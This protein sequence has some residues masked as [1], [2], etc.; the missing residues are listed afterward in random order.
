MI[1]RAY[2]EIGNV[3]NMNCSFCVG[4][5]RPPRQMSA[6]EFE[7]VARRLRGKTKYVYLHVLGEPLV[8]R[9]LVRILEIIRDSGLRAAITTNGTLI[10]E[11]SSELIEKSDVL[12][13]VSV[14]LHS[15]EGNGRTGGMHEY[16]KS[17]SDYAKRASDAGIY[18]V[19]RLWNSD[20]ERRAGQNSKN[21]EIEALLHKEFPEEWQSRRQG[22][23]LMK[24]VFLEYAEIFE[25]PSESTSAPKC[26]GRC[27]GMIDQIAVL[28]DGT[29]VPC[30]LDSEGEIALGNIFDSELE[31]ILASP[32]AVKMRE[33]LL[34]GRFSEDL[35][36]K[37]SYAHRFTK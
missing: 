26:E 1:E 14:S 31:E 22:Q 28:V 27:H 24:N 15:F 32:R 37:C 17:I 16:I 35:C 8:H 21:R 5:R 25:W 11:R 9:E 29:V 33:G 34:A 3:C 13:K 23:R 36:K 30:C 12:H 2:V 6:E 4:T 20:S 18:T 10:A 7:I 19:L